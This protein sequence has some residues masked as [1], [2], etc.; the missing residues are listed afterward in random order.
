MHHTF[1][2]LQQPEH[3]RCEQSHQAQQVVKLCPLL[4]PY[5]GLGKANASRTLYQNH[6]MQLLSA[7]VS[8]LAPLNVQS[9]PPVTPMMS[10]HAGAIFLLAFLWWGA[11][12]ISTPYAATSYRHHKHVWTATAT[13]A[14]LL[15]ALQLLAQ[16]LYGL[17]LLPTAGSQ[18]PDTSSSTAASI[19]AVVL[20]ALGLGSVE[21]LS[22]GYILLVSS[23]C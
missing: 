7:S 16:L 11:C 20:E 17:H 22:A 13:A 2:C 23:S 8:A 12:C 15:F 21:G 19:A 14:L 10:C 3:C 1:G 18:T 5:Y 6:H 4:Q 9:Q